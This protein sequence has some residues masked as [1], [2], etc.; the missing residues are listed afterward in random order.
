[1]S[2]STPHAQL[3]LSRSG[4]LHNYRHFRSK[5]KDT[6]KMLILVKANGYGHG[7]VDFAREMEKAGANYLGV[8][9]PVE[10][11]ELKKA[12]IGLPVLDPYSA[13]SVDSE[14]LNCLLVQKLQ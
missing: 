3:E 5:L 1:M 9:F 8:A 14:T 4:M 2:I 10:G 13:S 6:T 12:G 7:A 11:V